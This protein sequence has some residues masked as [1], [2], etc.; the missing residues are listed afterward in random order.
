MILNYFVDSSAT[1]YY[2]F[3]LFVTS[4]KDYVYEVYTFSKYVLFLY[5][6]QYYVNDINE[7]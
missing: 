4:A 2:R 6:L 5:T 1:G 7:S 3:L